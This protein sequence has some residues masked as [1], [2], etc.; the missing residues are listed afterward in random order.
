[1]YSAVSVLCTAAVYSLHA[2]VAAVGLPH[3]AQLRCQLLRLTP[4]AHTLRKKN[5]DTQTFSCLLYNGA[6][7]ALQAVF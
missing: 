7:L 1:M 4:A 6:N 5:D 2:Q 3:L